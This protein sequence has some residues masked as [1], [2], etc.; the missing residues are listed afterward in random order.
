MI[1]ARAARV[2][3]PLLVQGQHWHAWTE[4]GRL[5]FQ[6]ESGLLDLP[7]PVLAGPHQV[8]NAG[9]ALAALR[10]LGGGE[11][12]CEAAVTRAVWP[13]RMQR[14]RHGPL[15]DAAPAA[16]MLARRRATIRRR[17]WRSRRRSPRRPRGPTHL[18]CGMLNTK[19]MA[20]FLRPLAPHAGSLTAVPIPGEANT[21]DPATTARIAAAAGHAVRQAPDARTAVAQ[22]AA[23][24]PHARILV[25]GS[26]YLAGRILQENG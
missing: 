3:A 9:A 20:G 22:I 17:D 24:S 12:A 16:E 13:A 14:L 5:V 26:L 19:D 11:A 7:L 1:E 2:G 25:C 21:L 18:V 23:A 15:A 4:R 6:D 8:V 10:H